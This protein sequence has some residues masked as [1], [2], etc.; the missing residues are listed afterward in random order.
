[1]RFC[2]RATAR[3]LPASREAAAAL[4]QAP[5]QALYRHR[6]RS[7]RSRQPQQPARQRRRRR[8]TQLQR[9]H[10]QRGV[11]HTT[12]SSGR[13]GGRGVALWWRRAFRRQMRRRRSRRVRPCPAAAPTPAFWTR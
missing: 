7:G 5:R 8:Q 9:R 13:G 3:C 10:A 12:V 2:W 11:L 6:Q 4:M 1:M